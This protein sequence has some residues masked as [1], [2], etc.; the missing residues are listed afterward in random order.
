MKASSQEKPNWVI[1]P[2][3]SQHRSRPNR[4]CRHQ[5]HGTFRQRD[6]SSGATDEDGLPCS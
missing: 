2:G 3:W 6:N 5:D 1:P 4:A